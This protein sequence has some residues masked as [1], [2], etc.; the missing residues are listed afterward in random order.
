MPPFKVLKP[1]Q[2]S[3]SRAICIYGPPGVGKTT[4][5]RTLPGKG[6]VIDVPQLE[7]GTEVLS[8]CANIDIT[9][10]TSWE[11]IDAVYK[12]LKAGQ[13]SYRWVAIDTITAFVK[14]AARRI[15]AER[16]ISAQPHKLTLPERGQ[17][18]NLLAELVYRFRVLPIFTVWLAQQRKFSQD[19]EPVQYGP[20]VPPG[21]LQDLLPSMLLIGRYLPVTT[22]TN[23]L[24]RH[25]Q[26]GA[27]SDAMT[28]YRARPDL[29]VPSVVK[30][31]NIANLL[32]WLAGRTTDRDGN[33][34]VLEPA[35]PDGTFVDFGDLEVPNS[36][37]PV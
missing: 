28:K 36:L 18:N 13:H 23:E 14:L 21:A 35:E 9:P 11:E 20:A 5:L 15:V 4:L 37:T 31:P 19:D 6:L 22:V 32:L 26:I 34:I 10:V 12:F 1:G 16:E 27:R 8:G 25:L 30:N 33:Q 3:P 24:E 7:G 29:Q 17:I 2:M